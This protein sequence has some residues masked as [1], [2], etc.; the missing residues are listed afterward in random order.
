MS[1]NSLRLILPR[2]FPAQA[3]CR[4]WPEKHQLYTAQGKKVQGISGDASPLH[5]KIARWAIL[6]ARQHS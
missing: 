4:E 1:E 6:E 3:P 2:H 5:G